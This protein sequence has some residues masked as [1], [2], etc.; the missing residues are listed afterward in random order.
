M[1][2]VEVDRLD[3]IQIELRPLQGSRKRRQ[4]CLVGTWLI[5]VRLDRLPHLRLDGFG[6]RLLAL[7][8]VYGESIGRGFG[9]GWE[10][11]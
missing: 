11:G 2:R 5:Q 6:R 3:R 4:Y 10:P 1:E 9:D 8:R 7:G